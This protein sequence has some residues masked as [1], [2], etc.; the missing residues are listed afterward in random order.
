MT[1]AKSWG[2]DASLLTPAEIKELVP[3]INEEILLGGYYTPTVSVVDSLRAGTI[4]RERGGRRRASCKVFANTEVMSLE[5]ENGTIKAVNHRPGSHRSRIRRHRLWRVEPPHRRH[6]RRNDSAHTRRAP[7]GRRRPDRDPAKVGQGSRRTRSSAT[8]TPSVTSARAPVRWKSAPTRTDRSFHDAPTR[9]HRSRIPPCR[10]PSFRSHRRLRPADGAGP[11]ADARDSR[12]RRDQA[13]RSTVFCR[14]PP[15]PCR[16]SARPS[17][18]ATSG[19]PQPCG[20][21]K[22]PASPR[23]SP[24]G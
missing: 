18:C 8:W 21:R 2:I 14:S 11:R 19:R 9:S 22:V 24:S 10:R 17:K 3:F 23:S 15:T 1:S 20:S 13:T 16:F 6:G 7:D 5:T 4:M 12:D